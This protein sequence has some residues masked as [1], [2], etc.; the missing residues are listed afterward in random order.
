MKKL[1]AFSNFYHIPVGSL[2]TTGVLFIGLGMGF[3][4][5]T[6]MAAPH[7]T[8]TPTPGSG[9]HQEC[10]VCHNMAHNPHTITIDCHALPAH[11]AHGDREGPCEITPVQNP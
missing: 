4:F 7:D 11:L 6:A 5:W 1:R 10:V 8:P 3:G 2:K 9:G